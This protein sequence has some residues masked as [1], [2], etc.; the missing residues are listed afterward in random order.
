M[1][2]KWF[3][4]SP[5]VTFGLEPFTGEERGETKIRTG[6]QEGSRWIMRGVREDGGRKGVK[7]EICPEVKLG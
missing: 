1:R 6:G 5:P 2:E 7:E 3:F 4:F